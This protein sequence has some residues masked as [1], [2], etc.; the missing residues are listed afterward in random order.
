MIREISFWVPI[1]VPKKT[2][3]AIKAGF[4]VFLCPEQDSNLHIRT[5]TS[6]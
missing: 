6:P 3:P 2:K 5:D 1:R 4:E